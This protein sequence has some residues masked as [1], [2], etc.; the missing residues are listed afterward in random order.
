MNTKKEIGQ[1]DS[2]YNPIVV[3]ACAV[4][5]WILTERLSLARRDVVE[6]HTLR[7]AV[8]RT[9][10]PAIAAERRDTML[11]CA[12][13]REQAWTRH[14]RNPYLIAGT[15]SWWLTPWYGLFG[16][17]W[18]LDRTIEQYWCTGCQWAAKVT[19]G[20]EESNVLITF[21]LDTGAEVRAISDTVHWTLNTPLEQPS[22]IL[23]GPGRSVLHV[24][25]QSLTYHGS[26]STLQQ[27]FMIK[28]L[29]NDLLGLPV[30]TALNLAVQVDFIL[31]ESLLLYE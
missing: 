2:K 29:K 18:C 6:V 13:P 19:V 5:P 22:K 7:K 28:E 20:S 11:L 8:Q 17:C 3:D 1:G 9:M 26:R 23:Y 25:G 24:L 15:T 14:C 16:H 10:L 30:I 4:L 31:P 21:K 12:S 27:L